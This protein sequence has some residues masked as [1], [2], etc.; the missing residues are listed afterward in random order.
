MKTDIQFNTHYRRVKRDY[1]KAGIWR[2]GGWNCS[3]TNEG[4][5]IQE[6][7]KIQS[8]TKIIVPCHI[9]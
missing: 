2:N 6:N 9:A 1:S 8:M 5:Q 4:H 7:H 3:K